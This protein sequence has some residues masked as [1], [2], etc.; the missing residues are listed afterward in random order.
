ML[1]NNTINIFVINPSIISYH[2]F[3]LNTRDI[4]N[5]TR[6]ESPMIK[7]KIVLAEKSREI[8]PKHKVYVSESFAL[9]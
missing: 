8:F 4:D 6:I 7:R 3:S 1:V 5:I 9:K 2:G